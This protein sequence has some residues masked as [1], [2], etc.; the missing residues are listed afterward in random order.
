MISALRNNA[1]DLREVISR[2]WAPFELECRPTLNAQY[3]LTAQ[4]SR[5]FGMI[6]VGTAVHVHGVCGFTERP[7]L[8]ACVRRSGSTHAYGGRV[9]LRREGCNS[10]VLLIL[11]ACIYA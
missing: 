9:D 7:Y 3:H 8:N 11:K 4:L 5:I 1:P 10:E 2:Q 6:D